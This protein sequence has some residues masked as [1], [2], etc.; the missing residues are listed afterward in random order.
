MSGTG[1]GVSAGFGVGADTG[2]GETWGAAEVMSWGAAGSFPVFFFIFICFASR[3]GGGELRG[4]AIELPSLLKKSPI[5]LPA[6]AEWPPAK[7][8]ITDKI[9][10]TLLS[11]K[12]MRAVTL[13]YVAPCSISPALSWR[14]RRGPAPG[15]AARRPY[16][17]MIIVGQALRL[18]RSDGKRSACPTNK[19]NAIFLEIQLPQWREINGSP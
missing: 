15:R 6:P 3:R 19:S 9:R 18:P 4:C 17:T 12:S 7:N 2:A 10:A 8:A 13:H 1:M 16:P 14:G 5:G 11:G